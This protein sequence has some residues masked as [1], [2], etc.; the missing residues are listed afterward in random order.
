MFLLQFPLDTGAGA[1]YVLVKWPEF[2]SEQIFSIFSRLRK[3]S[4][5]ADSSGFGKCTGRRDQSVQSTWLGADDGVVS[6]PHFSNKKWVLEPGLPAAPWL[7]SRCAVGRCSLRL[8]TTRF[9]VEITALVTE[10]SHNGLSVLGLEL[11]LQSPVC[12]GI[13]V[14]VVITVASLTG[15]KRDVPFSDL[16]RGGFSRPSCGRLFVLSHCFPP[17]A[18]EH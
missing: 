10:L 4:W 6:A 1:Q 11:G 17:T 14:L 3:A 9:P 15:D 8:C 5:R 7:R 12:H 2:S 13:E 16:L 18:V